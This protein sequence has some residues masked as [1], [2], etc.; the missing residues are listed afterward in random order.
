MKYTDRKYSVEVVPKEFEDNLTSHAA[1]AVTKRIEDDAMSFSDVERRWKRKGYIVKTETAVFMGW[2]SD[3][4]K[5]E[6]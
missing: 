3:L 5:G 2:N 6:N 1:L 4:K